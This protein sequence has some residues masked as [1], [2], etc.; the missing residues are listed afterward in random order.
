M[1]LSTLTGATPVPR[2]RSQSGA[3]RDEG[4]GL[5]ARWAVDQKSGS[6]PRPQ[7]TEQ[8]ALNSGCHK[9]AENNE[10][11]APQIA[12]ES[13]SDKNEIRTKCGPV[14]GRLSGVI[15][16][17]GP[18]R[19]LQSFAKYAPCDRILLSTAPPLSGVCQSVNPISMPGRVVNLCQKRGI[20]KRLRNLARRPAPPPPCRESSASST[21]RYRHDQLSL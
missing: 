16:P 11:T 10:A 15:S 9:V 7:S 3:G 5:N 20:G 13:P 14:F 4:C 18:T 12:A 21:L 2:L 8:N 19:C 17:N 1:T 6:G